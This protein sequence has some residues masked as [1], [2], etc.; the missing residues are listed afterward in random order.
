MSPTINT[1]DHVFVDTLNARLP[2]VFPA[3]HGIKRGDLIV[4]VDPHGAHGSESSR[5][6]VVK[7][8]VGLPGDRLHIAEGMLI[9]NGKP[10]YEPYLKA[11]DNVS[12]S[13]S[14]WPL[15]AGTTPR[16]VL[17]PPDSVFVLGDNRDVSLDSRIYGPLA[18]ENIVGKVIWLSS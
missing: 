10:I 17:I 3:L 1:G 4:F 12:M 2:F 5:D 16:D 18:S 8:V 6:F 11:K 14:S 15:S 9:V 13:F 7:R